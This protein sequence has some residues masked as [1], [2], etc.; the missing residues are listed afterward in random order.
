MAYVITS[1]IKNCPLRPKFGEFVMKESPRTQIYTTFLL[2][3]A[4]VNPQAR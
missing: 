4:L 3:K 2:C 1:L